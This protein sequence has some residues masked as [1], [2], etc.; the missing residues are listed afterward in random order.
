MEVLS[1]ANGMPREECPSL[2]IPPGG[3]R[4]SRA[5]GEL[6]DLYVVVETPGLLGGE[7]ERELVQAI[8][9]EYHRTSG[10]V[11]AGLIRAVKAANR[12]LWQENQNALPGMWQLAGMSCAVV[13]EDDLFLA[14]AGPSLAYLIHGDSIS[15]IPAESPWLGGPPVK[16]QP[17]SQGLGTASDLL[18]DLFHRDL[19]PGD[20]IV[21]AQTSLA[22][23]LADE[24]IRVALAGHDPALGVGRL[25][26]AAGTCTL[27]CIVIQVQPVGP[28][29]P[30]QALPPKGARRPAPTAH[31]SGPPARRR[32]KVEKPAQ[33]AL[34]IQA[35]EFSA[36]KEKGLPV[37]RAE[38]RPAPPVTGL[39]SNSTGV[40]VPRVI[41]LSVGGVSARE[42]PRASER[43]LLTRRQISAGIRAAWERLRTFLLVKSGLS[44]RRRWMVALAVL[45]ALLL[46]LGLALFLRFGL[47]RL[48]EARATAALGLAARQ[49]EVAQSASD[50][51]HRSQALHAAWK[52][53]GEARSLAP[54]ERQW[55][56][57]I[58]G[59]QRG[60]DRLARVVRLYGLTVLADFRKEDVSLSRVVAQGNQLFVL[61]R[62][63]NQ[64]Y[65][66]TLSPAGDAIQ[67]VGANPVLLQSGQ[68]VGESIVGK[69]VDMTGRPGGIL[70]LD[71]DGNVFSYDAEG[72]RAF[73]LDDHSRWQAPM[74]MAADA[75][76]LYLL[77]T[78]Q[79]QIW[80]YPA[81]AGGYQGQS[82]DY[83]NSPS[84]VDL[85]RAVD[86]QVNG[87]VYVLMADGAMARFDS[88]KSQPFRW[89]GLDQ[90]ISA[91][92]W[93]F[94]APAS[95]SLYVVERVNR[96]VLQFAKDGRYLRQFQ[97]GQLQ[98]GKSPWVLGQVRGIAVDEE[99][100]RIF[101]LTGNRLYLAYLPAMEGASP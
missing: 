67:R 23:A 76:N 21:L 94:V 33:L 86:L 70:A 39:S 38:E 80:K 100:G 78:K 43:R 77:D 99:H 7:A 79:S 35:E 82:S 74:A 29:E 52:A 87:S 53:L 16:D 90:P 46:L 17:S 69:L 95:G 26:Q 30:G 83:F 37:P 48:R 27:A 28:S 91:P 96:R 73:R 93:L 40:T 98:E 9:K 50:P 44:V 71:Q 18:P 41:Q 92:S 101:L 20:V 75:G 59:V 3:G 63:T 2:G 14:Q 36:G 58:D 22:Q 68:R 15:R 10:S 6:G 5:G 4:F 85:A 42:A 24:A 32:P 31:Q 97:E 8:E 72:L 61:D 65:G 81:R 51:D 45:L 49:L 88:G 60:L 1:L 25:A 57:E 19:E 13:R 56:T 34:P 84:P 54:P 12:Q 64:V 11:T 62:G 89:Q 47:P 66:L 55:I